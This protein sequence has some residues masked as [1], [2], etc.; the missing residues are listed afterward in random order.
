MLNLW[1]KNEQA[2]SIAKR[3]L[4]SI[5]LATNQLN[6]TNTASFH[7]KPVT[8]TVGIKP[9]TGDFE[10]SNNIKAW[11]PIARQETVFAPNVVGGITANQA[12]AQASAKPWEN[13]DSD[14]PF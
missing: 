14:I 11:K 6:A 2:V 8:I 1:N 4:A 9:A 12:P 7:S 5:K 3:E 10:A 13:K